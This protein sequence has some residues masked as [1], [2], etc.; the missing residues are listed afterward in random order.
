MTEETGTNRIEKKIL[1]RAPRARVWRALTDPIEFGTWF[2]VK[3]SAGSFV[4]GEVAR[5]A[6]INADP[7]YAN[8]PFEI[9]IEKMEPERLFSWRWHPGAVERDRD[10][11]KDPTTLVVFSLEESEG[12]T[13]LTVV[14]SGFDKVPAAYRATA[15]RLNNEGWTEQMKNIERY[16]TGATPRR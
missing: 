12:G 2:G 11:S 1:L 9:T 15:F 10:Y 16:V 3:M 6:I 7:Q 8:L 13:L 5:G 14:E 4:P